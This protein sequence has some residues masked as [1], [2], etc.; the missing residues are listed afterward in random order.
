[1]GGGDDDPLCR[2][3]FLARVVDEFLAVHARHFQIDDEQIDFV[4]DLRQRVVWVA[5]RFD[6]GRIGVAFVQE[7]AP[8]IAVRGR[9]VDDD[10]AFH[11]FFF[12]CFGSGAGARKSYCRTPP[13]IVDTTRACS[14]SPMNGEFEAFD[15]N[16]FVT[17]NRALRSSTAMSAGEPLRSVP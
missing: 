3:A 4:V 5:V 8:Q 13:T 11:F 14:D 6:A 10:D 2:D 9:V 15:A 12:R 16:V 1:M 17:W 7:S